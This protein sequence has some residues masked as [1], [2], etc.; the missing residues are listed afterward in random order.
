MQITDDPIAA[1]NKQT[2]A[3]AGFLNALGI[4]LI[5]FAALR[6]LTEDPAR[7]TTYSLLWTLGG[8]ALHLIAH[9]VLGQMRREVKP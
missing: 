4:G 9:Y 1:H 5:G 7:M 8:L 3:Q 6:P 2:K